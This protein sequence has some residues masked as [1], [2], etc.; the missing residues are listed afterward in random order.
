MASLQSLIINDTGSINL[1]L[2]TTAQR[3]A[4][5][6]EGY[7]RYNTTLSIVEFYNGDAWCRIDNLVQASASGAVA[8][9]E[10]VENGIPYTVHTFT[11]TGSLAVTSPGEIEYVVVAGGGGGGGWGG[12]GGGGGFIKGTSLVTPQTYTITVGAGGAKGTSAYSAGGNGAS[13]SISGIATAT[14]GGGGGQWSTGQGASGGSG[15]GSSGSQT[16]VGA[17]IAGQGYNG[18]SGPGTTQSNP[19]F[20][21]GGGGGAGE[22][23]QNGPS[24][25]QRTLGGKGGDGRC[26][27]I[28]GFPM[29]FSGGG[30]GHSPGAETT[31][32]SPGGKGGGGRSGNYYYPARA[33]DGGVNT[34]GGGG[35]NWGGDN[36]RQIGAG[37]SGIVIIRYRKKT[38][39]LGKPA[40]VFQEGLMIHLDGSDI[41]SYDY[42]ANP[43]VWKNIAGFTGNATVFGVPIFEQTT[44]GGLLLNGTSQ[45]AEIPFNADGMDF[46]KAQTICMWLRPN[47]N[48]A[49]R[50]NPYN[51]AYGGSGTWTHEPSGEINYYFGT[52]GGNGSPYVGATSGFTVGQDELAFVVSLR[53]QDA[54][55]QAWYKNGELASEGTA[56]GY[57]ATA[58]GTAPILIGLGYTTYY[59][60]RIYEVMVYNQALSDLAVK[61]LYEATRSK[62]GV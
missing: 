29:W 8:T 37:G 40:K 20:G 10:V 16:A 33:Y 22:P 28:K 12:G 25:V 50:R 55:Y 9:T 58:N 30:A 48:D 49:N 53:D 47:E 5:P 31:G 60:G 52:N 11:G 54:N 4:N 24:P 62:Y 38:G 61:Q 39:S 6:Q 59:S 57:K 34:G 18:G 7:I 43:T 21:H 13:S 27:T 45:Y 3:P 41:T 26:T 35:G 51:Q 15:G 42:G 46:S 56:G 1:P 36:D 14:G 17:G 23:G 44:A 19:Y 32:T 2:G